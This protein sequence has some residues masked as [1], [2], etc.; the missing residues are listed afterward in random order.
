MLFFSFP[1]ERKTAPVCSLDK[2]GR[3]G[4]MDTERALLLRLAQVSLHKLKVHADRLGA[5]KRSAR[6][7][8]EYVGQKDQAYQKSPKKFLHIG[9]TPFPGSG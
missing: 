5:T 3:D 6:F 7:Y 8:G 1:P 9:L 2:P 4:I